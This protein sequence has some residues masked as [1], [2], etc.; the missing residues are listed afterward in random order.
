M[1]TTAALAEWDYGIY[2]G[3]LTG[4]IRKGRKTRGLDGEAEGEWDIWRHGCE[5]GE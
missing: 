5:D 3:L 4:E 2:E 1:S